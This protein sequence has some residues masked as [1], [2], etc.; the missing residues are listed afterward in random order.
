MMK[1][2]IQR[3][4]SQG[5]ADR[6]ALIAHEALIPYYE[7]FGF[8]NRGKSEAKFGGGGW[9]NLVRDLKSEEEMEE[10]VVEEEVEVEE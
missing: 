3:M 4:E 1:A 6:L 5:V 7:G 8:E 9:F 2:Y 10:V